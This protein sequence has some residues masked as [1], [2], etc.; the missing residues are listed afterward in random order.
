MP[1]QAP[2]PS[3]G[4][5]AASCIVTWLRGLSGTPRRLT[6]GIRANLR[7]AARWFR[8]SLGCGIANLRIGNA[9][10][11]QTSSNVVQTG[12][13]LACCKL[14]FQLPV[15]IGSTPTKATS[16][17]SNHCM[18]ARHKFLVWVLRPSAV[19]C[20]VHVTFIP[21]WVRNRSRLVR[22]CTPQHGPNPRSHWMCTN[23][24][25][26]W[27]FESLRASQGPASF[28]AASLPARTPG[29]SAG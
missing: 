17:G 15:Q 6:R 20:R 22:I 3:A 9:C 11:F 7:L 10:S 13:N 8:A 19:I 25:N 18:P 1:S 27:K 29:F 28:T 4:V 14:P 21:D 16:G 24:S 5:P 12:S 2:I 26:I 23:G